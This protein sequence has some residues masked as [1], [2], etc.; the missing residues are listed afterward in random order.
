MVSLDN[1]KTAVSAIKSEINSIASRYL[2]KTDA[3]S[4]YITKKNAKNSFATKSSVPKILGFDDVSNPDNTHNI[5]SLKFPDS[6]EDYDTVLGFIKYGDYSEGSLNVAGYKNIQFAFSADTIDNIYASDRG[7]LNPGSTSLWYLK[8]GESVTGVFAIDEASL[9]RAKRAALSST[10]KEFNTSGSMQGVIYHDVYVDSINFRLISTNR[11][12]HSPL[13]ERL[14]DI[15]S[16]QYG[17]FY[18]VSDKIT[19]DTP[20]NIPFTITRI[21]GKQPE[22]YD[23]I[24]GVTYEGAD[25][26]ISGIGA[27]KYE[28]LKEKLT[29][30]YDKDV[31]VLVNIK[32]YGIPGM[33]RYSQVVP[34]LIEY[35]EDTENIVLTC[36]GYCNK[37]DVYTKGWFTL[38]IDSS[39]AVSGPTA[40]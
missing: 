10:G 15:I 29:S 28:T 9:V 2:K 14:Y 25:F 21:D 34:S 38:A 24:L 31:R 20:V 40:L 11:E 39:G 26:S 3:D 8:S 36:Y 1:L 35:Q 16:T 27:S 18:F 37:H 30:V 23:A 33:D 22:E 4:I 7:S 6:I 5:R 17:L 12:S 19:E 32:I 13:A